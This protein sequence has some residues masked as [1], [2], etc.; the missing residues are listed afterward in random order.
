MK[1]LI[2]PVLIYAFFLGCS[3]NKVRL[4]ITQEIK[5]DIAND[6]ADCAVVSKTVAQFRESEALLVKRKTENANK[7]YHKKLLTEY[8]WK[9]R[10]ITDL[11]ETINEKVWPHLRQATIEDYRK[12]LCGYICKNPDKIDEFMNYDKNIRDYFGYSYKEKGDS[13]HYQGTRTFIFTGFFVAKEDFIMP[14]SVHRIEYNW[15]DGDE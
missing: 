6:T 8:F 2:L 1:K 9:N 7:A 11:K 5:Y 10:Y 14:P 13:R 15:V 4:P 3:S 12:W